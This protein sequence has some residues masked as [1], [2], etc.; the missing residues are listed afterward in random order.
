MKHNINRGSDVKVNKT[1]TEAKFIDFFNE[2]DSK[3]RPIEV[4]RNGFR[5]IAKFELVYARPN[6]DL[7]RNLKLSSI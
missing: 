4:L 2:T 5:D 7:N 1:H 6:N 3:E